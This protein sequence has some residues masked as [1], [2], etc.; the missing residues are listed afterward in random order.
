MGNESGEGRIDRV[1]GR[2][3][4]GTQQQRCVDGNREKAKINAVQ[5][6]KGF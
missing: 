5:P 4:S 1:K 6:G 3:A 2:R